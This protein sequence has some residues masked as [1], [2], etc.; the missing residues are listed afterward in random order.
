MPSLPSM[1]GTCNTQVPN[2]P[3]GIQPADE[4]VQA[5]CKQIERMPIELTFNRTKIEAL[6]VEIAQLY[7]GFPFSVKHHPAV[8]NRAAIDHGT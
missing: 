4:T 3:Q 8:V 7:K 1:L 5:M 2:T 6:N